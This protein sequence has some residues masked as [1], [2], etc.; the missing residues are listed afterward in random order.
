[1]RPHTVTV[2]R[3]HNDERIVEHA[4]L[5]QL[6]Q[7]RSHVII[8]HFTIMAERIDVITPIF[9][10]ITR[11]LRR[12]VVATANVANGQRQVLPIGHAV[13]GR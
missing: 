3:H 10:G 8:C 13:I 1:M 12:S 4:L 9:F 7:H 6:L 11:R 5:L 2:I